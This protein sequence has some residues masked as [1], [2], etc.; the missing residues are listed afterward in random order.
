MGGRIMNEENR[1]AIVEDNAPQRL[2]LTRLLEAGHAV[3]AFSSGDAFLA[4]QPDV[5][6]VLLDIEMPGLDGYE[7]C[8]RLRAK[9]SG[10]GVP[11]LF[12]SA[13]D[14]APERLTAYEAGGD[15]F[16][17]KPISAQ[18]LLHKV[19]TLIARSRQMRELEAHSQAAQQVA[20]AAMSS[21]GDLGAVLEFMRRSAAAEDL[22][23]LARL[24][25]DAMHACGLRG[26]AEVRGN[27]GRC[28]CVSDDLATP[29]Q[30]SVLDNLRQMGRIFE[31]GS[32]AVLNY[33][34]VSLLVNNLPTDDPG[35]VGRL[36]DHLALLAE[37]ADI[38]VGAYEAR[39]ERLQ[40]RDSA[41]ASLKTLQQAIE[42]AAQ[43]SRD[44]REHMQQHAFDLLGNLERSLGNMGLT[45]IQEGY[46]RDT[47]RAGADDLLRH[48]DEA[49]FIES[50]FDD[51][52]HRL[53]DIVGRE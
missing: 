21:M 1:I 32:R 23:T 40:Q 24:L 7:V 17:T 20:F 35:K 8:R 11:V 31:F 48:F 51:A 52:L 39:T 25:L 12:V 28:N 13:H 45:D 53:H 5:D 15:D 18:E 10:A 16:I 41:T 19:A 14:T 34:H 43:R 50:D 36:R 42:R 47:V 44:N 49:R 9:V 6:C 46:V 37:A 26:I 22:G 33:A 27:S 3:Q 38:R 2:I 29:L 30:A 4:A